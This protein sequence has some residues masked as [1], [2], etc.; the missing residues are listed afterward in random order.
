MLQMLHCPKNG[1]Q[2]LCVHSRVF[3]LRILSAR[4]KPGSDVQDIVATNEN[5]SERTCHSPINPFLGIFQLY[6]HICINRLEVACEELSG[7]R[8][9]G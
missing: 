8:K 2:K 3:G 5:F 1:D 7:S 4:C 6:V 9:G